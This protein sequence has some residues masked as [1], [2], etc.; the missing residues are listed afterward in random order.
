M[1]HFRF[2]A[3]K[4]TNELQTC[5]KFKEEHQNV[6]RDYGITNVTSNNDA[7]MYDPAM[8][9]IVAEQNR[10]IV[11]GVRLQVST[12]RGLLPVENAIGKMDELIYTVVD[13][14]RNS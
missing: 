2:R 6:L 3:F 1:Q 11:G 13:K 4:A 9:C 12:R 14:Y 10:K 5:L 7:W 8:F